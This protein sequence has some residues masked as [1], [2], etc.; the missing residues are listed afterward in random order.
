MALGK[1]EIIPSAAD[2]NTSGPGSLDGMTLAP[3]QSFGPASDTSLSTR[4][5]TRKKSSSKKAKYK[6]RTYE[7]SELVDDYYDRLQTAEQNKPAAYTQGADVTNY[8][9][10][11]KE[12]E[13][14][15]PG[16]FQSR[17]ESQIQN[18]LSG[19]LDDKGFSYTGK[20]MLS[21]DLY[22]LYRDQYTKEGNLAMRDAAGNAA[23]LTGGYGST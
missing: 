6:T 18:I 14:N 15:K 8:Q 10:R 1:I 5:A 9:N 23:G 13:A 11:L 3:G 20:D 2:T 17:Y 16:A 12:L 4:S 7:R 21:D 22:K 19:I